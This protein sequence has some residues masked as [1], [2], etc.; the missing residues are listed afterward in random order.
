MAT[1]GSTKISSEFVHIKIGGDLAFFKG[2]MKVMFEREA[3]GETVLDHELIRTHTVG[4][5]A[6]R[7]DALAQDWA[8]I[9]EVSGLAEEQIRRCAEIYIRS[10]ATIICY[11]MGLTQ[12]QLGSQLLQQVSN[13]L[14]LRG[15]YGKLGA[16]ISPIRGHSNVQ[17]DRT[18]G[19]DERPS[20]CLLYTSRCV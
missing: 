3:A 11:G 10:N 6:I 7:D 15:N 8:E 2:I 1:F 16:G 19:I 18:V 12:H 14:L 4:I 13:L 20:P 9:V 5:E 17:G